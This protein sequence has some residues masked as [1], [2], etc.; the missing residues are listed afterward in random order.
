[1]IRSWVGY[2]LFDG[3]THGPSEASARVATVCSRLVE[4]RADM[5]HFACLDI[6]KGDRIQVL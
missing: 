6:L 5:A 2:R 3:Q 4:R 1:M